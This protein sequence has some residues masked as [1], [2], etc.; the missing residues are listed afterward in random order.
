MKDVIWDKPF[1]L[2]I[3]HA[4]YSSTTIYLYCRCP[5]LRVM[6]SHLSH[7]V[8]LWFYLSDSPWRSVPFFLFTLIQLDEQ[9][10]K[11]LS[12]S[13]YKEKGAAHVMK[14]IPFAVLVCIYC[15]LYIDDSQLMLS[16]LFHNSPSKSLFTYVRSAPFHHKQASQVIQ[17]HTKEQI[18]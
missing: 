2:R 5:T 9:L 1:E 4:Q 13:Y 3:L 14:D 10:I 18:Y 16:R 6:G 17:N 8:L 15:V 12:E 7:N 11:L